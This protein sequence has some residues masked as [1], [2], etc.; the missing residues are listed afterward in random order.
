[1]EVV[2]TADDE[3]ARRAVDHLVALGHRD[4][5]HI[6]GGRAPGAADRRR[7][8]R[9]AMQRHGLAD[10]VRVLPGGLTEEDGATA[11]RELL[12][13]DPRPT[14]VLA[15]NDRSATGVL[16]ILL[17]ARVSVPDEISVIGFDD[18]HLA[19]LAHINL[20]TVG[21]D[22]PRL[23]ELAVGRAIARLE[24]ASTSRENTTE[25]ARGDGT[26]RAEAVVAPRLVIRGTTAG[27]GRVPGGISPGSG[28]SGAHGASAGG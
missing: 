9:T 4:I 11:A 5:A 15:F 28:G 3:G 16:D 18:T 21:Q 26:L 13:A 2:R 23:A 12:A 7:G 20:T 27:P 14:A 22:I 6:D 24:G 8:Y 1:M 17:R 19:R 10:R 25:D